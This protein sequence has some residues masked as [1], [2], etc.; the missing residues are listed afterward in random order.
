[1][2][3]NG[4]F[5]RENLENSTIRKCLKVLSNEKIKFLF[6]GQGQVDTWHHLRGLPEASW[7]KN[8]EFSYKMPIS[9]EIQHFRTSSNNLHD[10]AIWK[11]HQHQFRLPRA[12]CM[13]VWNFRMVMWNQFLV[14]PLSW[15][16]NCFLVH[17]ARLCEFSACSCE[18]RILDF[19]TP[20][21][22]FLH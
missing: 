11:M 10:C 2:K 14:F 19:S 13:T 12:F 16:Q 17:F 3:Q 21:C 9:H 5:Y 6:I 22:H 15:S 4:E 18:M 8:M 20:F 1:M 7:Q